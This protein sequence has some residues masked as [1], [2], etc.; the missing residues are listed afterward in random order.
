MIDGKFAEFAGWDWLIRVVCLYETNN[1]QRLSRTEYSVLLQQTADNPPVVKSLVDSISVTFLPTGLISVLHLQKMSSDSL[2]FKDEYR[3]MLR[4]GAFDIPFGIDTIML[5]F[6]ARDETGTTEDF[7]FRMIR[8]E[9]SH[10]KLGG[11]PKD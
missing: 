1:R 6:T 4:F 3:C 2:S 7:Q 10:E 11:F 5:A 8:Y 9:G